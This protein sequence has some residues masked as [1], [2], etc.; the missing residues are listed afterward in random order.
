[1][2]GACSHACRVPLW[3]E[4]VWRHFHPSVKGGLF[5][6]TNFALSLIRK[7][8]EYPTPHNPQS[9]TERQFGHRK[10]TRAVKESVVILKFPQMLLQ[11]IQILNEVS[12]INRRSA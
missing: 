11:P 3:W 8:D 10:L 6:H 5:G 1:M 9:A 7:H 2:I 12:K 4:Q